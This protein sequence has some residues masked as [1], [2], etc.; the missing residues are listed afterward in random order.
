MRLTVD[1][2]E[3]RLRQAGVANISDVDHA[4]IEVSGGNWVM[5]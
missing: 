2:L 1:K 5:C 4:A 3:V